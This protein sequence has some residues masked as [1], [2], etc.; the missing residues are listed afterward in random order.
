MP[1][2]MTM[3]CDAD[4][5]KLEA[6][7]NKDPELM[8]VI[9]SRARSYGLVSH[10]FYGSPTEVLVLDEWPDEDSFRKFFDASPEIGPL[11][12]RAGMRGEPQITFWRT[13]NTN[14]EVTAATPAPHAATS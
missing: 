14:D 4:A 2:L 7:T 6:E 8:H 10:R 1:V 13:L 3:R 5:A 12:A 11:M 9:V